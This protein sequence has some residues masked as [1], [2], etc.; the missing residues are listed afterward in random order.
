MRQSSHKLDALEVVFDDPT[1][2]AN[3]GL[4]LPMTLAGR[5]GLKELVDADVC[6]R[7][8]PGVRQRRPKGAGP[9]PVGSGRVGSGGWRPDP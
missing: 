1:A 7:S 5:L 2:V 3:G 8:C 6:R 4:V 9:G